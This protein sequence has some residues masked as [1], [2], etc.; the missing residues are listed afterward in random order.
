MNI[1]A[2]DLLLLAGRPGLP[3]YHHSDVRRVIANG[4]V[5]VKSD[6]P[7]ALPTVLRYETGDFYNGHGYA[8]PIES[9]E[10]EADASS[11]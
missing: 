11:T 1:L 5:R 8:G 10:S 2:Q 7:R 4:V 3:V 6:R 9:S